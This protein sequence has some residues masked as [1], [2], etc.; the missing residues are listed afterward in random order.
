MHWFLKHVMT[1][2]LRKLAL[3][4]GAKINIWKSHCK[5]QMGGEQFGIVFLGATLCFAASLRQ[6]LF[7]CFCFPFTAPLTYSLALY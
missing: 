1:R 7:L 5:L 6:T 2:S 4:A 3:P